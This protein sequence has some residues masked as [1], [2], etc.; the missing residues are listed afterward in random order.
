MDESKDKKFDKYFEIA[1][2]AC[3]F[4]IPFFG[5]KMALKNYLQEDDLSIFYLLLLLFIGGNIMSCMI[6]VLNEKNLKIKSMWTVI[7]LVAMITLNVL[8]R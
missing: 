7:L 4:L 2:M 3:Y 8:L 5:F 1:L 6:F